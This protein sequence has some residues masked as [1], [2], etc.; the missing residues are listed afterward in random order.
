M[1]IVLSSNQGLRIGAWP[2]PT[3]TGIRFVGRAESSLRGNGRLKIFDAA[4]RTTYRRDIAVST[5]RFE[6]SWDGRSNTGRRV[7]AGVY[8]AR[9]QLGAKAGTVRVVISE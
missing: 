7:T 6:V 2:N 8:L 1:A 5:E 4:G 3:R 9:F